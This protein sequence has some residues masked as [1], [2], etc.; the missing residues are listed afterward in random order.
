MFGNFSSRK[1]NNRKIFFRKNIFREK[2]KRKYNF[3]NFQYFFDR[4]EVLES[5]SSLVSTKMEVLV[6]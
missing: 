6:V 2:Q 3:L 4:I 5:L 1:K